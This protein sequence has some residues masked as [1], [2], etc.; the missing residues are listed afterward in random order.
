[1]TH[2]VRLRRNLEGA[3]DAFENKDISAMK[4]AHSADLSCSEAGHEIPAKM[5]RMC[6]LWGAFEGS[7][8]ATAIC[9]ALTGADLETSNVITITISCILT[10][11][12]A[13]FARDFIRYR[14]ETRHY[15]RERARESW[16]LK[17]FPE[18]ETQEMVELYVCKGLKEEDARSVIHTVA[19]YEE[20]FVDLMMQ[21]ELQLPKLDSSP[22][23]C[24]AST[25]LGFVVFASLPLGV[26]WAICEFLAPAFHHPHYTF[27][28]TTL[29]ATAALYIAYALLLPGRSRHS[30]PVLVFF[31]LLVTAYLAHELPNRVR[32]H[33]L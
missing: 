12:V 6:A 30:Y 3:R 8:I 9:A 13:L 7:A 25:W 1:M 2:G 26:F 15:F 16:E 22:V 21:Q 19:K 17:N 24:A 23:Q 33:R 10:L 4:Q 20:F 14:G 5:F 29:V 18:G 11:S 31:S 27:A 32:Q 28:A